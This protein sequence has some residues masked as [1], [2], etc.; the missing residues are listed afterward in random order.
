MLLGEYHLDGLRFDQVTIITENG[1]WLF[2]Q[3]VTRTL[4]YEQP[5]TALI[6][7]YW[8]EPWQAVT[9]PPDGMGFDLTYSDRLRDAVRGLIAAAAGGANDVHRRGDGRGLGGGGRGYVGLVNVALQDEG[10]EVTGYLGIHRDVSERKRAGEALR[11]A[12]RRP[13]QHQ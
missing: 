6:A 12:Q 8:G 1:G 7:E 13:G 2:C 11:E 9:P 4:H 3:D 5:N 10:G